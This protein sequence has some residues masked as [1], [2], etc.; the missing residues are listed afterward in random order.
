MADNKQKIKIKRAVAHWPSLN[1]SGTYKGKETG[2]YELKTILT[3]EQLERVKAEVDEFLVD[4][5][6]PKRAKTATSPFKLTK[7]KEG[8]QA[9]TYITFRSKTTTKDGEPRTLPLF[10]SKGNP[11]PKAKRPNVGSG[12]IVSVNGTMQAF[13][14]DVGVAFYMDEVQIIKLVSF[15]SGEGFEADA[16]DE[17]GYVADEFDNED[18]DEDD[19]ASS[20]DT[21][22]EKD[23][24]EP[25]P[26][27]PKRTTGKRNF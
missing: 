10:D 2:N 14:E 6:G 1:R 15:T 20:E 21:A 11:I 23:A 22:P 9:Q 24:D 7:P 18:G 12:S 8:E 5:Y 25:A 16:D 19:E 17:D 3:G 13:K 26:A 4:T 27:K